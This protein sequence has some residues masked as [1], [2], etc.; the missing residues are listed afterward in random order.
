MVGVRPRF[1]KGEL[2]YHALAIYRVMEE[3]LKAGIVTFE[4]SERPNAATGVPGR[5]FLWSLK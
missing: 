5:G 1:N 4:E 2:D 3:L